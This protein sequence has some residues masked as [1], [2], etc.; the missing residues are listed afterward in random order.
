M[1]LNEEVAGS[2]L[3]FGVNRL[4]GVGVDLH[5]GKSGLV[6]DDGRHRPGRFQPV[7]R[8]LRNDSSVMDR[9]RGTGAIRPNAP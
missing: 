3:L 7:V 9:L 6:K 4:G 8:L 2:R 1:R 5:P